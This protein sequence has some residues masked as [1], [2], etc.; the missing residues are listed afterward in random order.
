MDH[1]FLALELA[2]KKNCL[3]I[4]YDLQ[5]ICCVLKILTLQEYVDFKGKKN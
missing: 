2:K 1:M 3:E 5:Y 4:L